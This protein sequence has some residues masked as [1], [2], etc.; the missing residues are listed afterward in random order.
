MRRTKIIATLGPSS[1]NADAV[2]KLIDAG[3]NVFRFNMKH[4]TPEWHSNLMQI[5]EKVCEEKGVRVGMLLDLQGPEIRITQ[6]LEKKTIHKGETIQ[7][8]APGGVGIA[9]D[10]SSVFGQVAV[11]QKVFI[12]DG[13]VELEITEI[14][15]NHFQ[16]KVIEGGVVKDRKT[17]NFPGAKLT[18]PTLIDRD[19][20]NLSLAARHEVDFV[21]L[22]FVRSAENIRILQKEMEKM[23]IKARIIA[24]IEHPDAVEN[25]D[26][27][28][29]VS[30]GIMVARGDLGIEYPLEEVPHLQKMMVKKAR[31]EGRVVIIATQMLE[32]MVTNTRPTRAE[33]SD[34][35]N[36]V[37]DGADAIM[38]SAESASG[39]YPARAVETMARI[40]M[41]V[42]SLASA[43]AIT[44][45]W[46]E[47]GEESMMVGSAV[48]LLRLFDE[49]EMEIAA[50][51]LVTDSPKTVQY[52]SRLRPHVPIIVVS[53]K[54]RIF[55]Q[56]SLSWG[57]IPV[58]N[59]SKKI[60]DIVPQL[61]GFG[62]T[63]K[64]F[65]Q[66]KRIIVLAPVSHEKISAIRL[67]HI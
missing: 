25:F 48:E 57:V 6:L 8:C 17:V 64:Y 36:A 37:Y 56:L 44:V 42:D 10:H 39:K 19:L 46:K 58:N 52:L 67:L 24:K 30:D 21:A 2:G 45:D 47:G 4:N 55:D 7:F 60:S 53:S 20:E 41:R 12:D 13:V 11:G 1:D 66:G 5:V 59:P 54:P 38:L 27:I 40:A 43:P 3:A 61:S 9:L 15:E 32:S 14:S 16:T 50:M 49:A 29:L 62:P 63:A 34:V 18:F 23:D 35:A 33:V 51:L 26:E 28:V 65:T 31:E 22:S